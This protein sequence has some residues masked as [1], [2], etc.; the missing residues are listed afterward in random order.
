MPGARGWWRRVGCRRAAGPGP[1]AMRSSWSTTT[2]RWGRWRPPRWPCWL[3]AN[4]RARSTAASARRS[5]GNRTRP[6]SP[7]SS[8]SS[9]SASR[10]AVASSAPP[11]GSNE[12]RSSQRPASVCDRCRERCGP[13]SGSAAVGRDDGVGLGRPVAHDGGGLGR[14]Q[15][16]QHRHDLGLVFGVEAGGALGEVAEHGLHLAARQHARRPGVAGGRQRAQPPRRRASRGRPQPEPGHS[17]VAARPAAR[18]RRRGPSH[19]RRRTGRPRP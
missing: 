3:S 5:A 12:P 7:P 10:R 8:P 14:R 11:S 6:P 16:G 15:A 9:D 18:W 4:Q 17:G 1:A 19:R 13:P 2:L